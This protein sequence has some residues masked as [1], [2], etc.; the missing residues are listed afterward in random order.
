MV[1]CYQEL[2]HRL[3]TVE[4]VIYKTD[5]E[6]RKILV[7]LNDMQYKSRGGGRQY[8]AFY[9]IGP[10]FDMSQLDGMFVFNKGRVVEKTMVKWFKE[11]RRRAREY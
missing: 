6:Y 5:G 10:D 11:N 1:F 2:D 3:K 7:V 9:E 8:L 4:I